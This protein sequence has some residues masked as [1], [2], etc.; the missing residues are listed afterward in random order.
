MRSHGMG[1]DANG[2]QSTTN[3]MAFESVVARARA[4]SYSSSSSSSSSSMTRAG[5]ILGR[6]ARARTRAGRRDGDDASD[7][8][9]SDDGRTKGSTRRVWLKTCGGALMSHALAMGG[10]RALGDDAKAAFGEV[11]ASADPWREARAARARARAAERRAIDERNIKERQAQEVENERARLVYAEQAARKKTRARL[12]REDE[13][14][15]E[16]IDREVERAGADARLALEKGLAAEE[17]ELAAYE[18][19]MAE[20]RATAEARNAE[21]LDVEERTIPSE[22]E[23]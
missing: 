12:E 8:T 13:L 21:F 16:E 3:A 7:E 6:R 15:P 1:C 10:M 20:R 9:P 4:Y 2:R 22:S 18:R 23:T 14:T 11:P 5:G 19:R 17:I